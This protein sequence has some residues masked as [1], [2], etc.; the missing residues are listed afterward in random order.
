MNEVDTKTGKINGNGSRELRE[1]S[2][3]GWDNGQES[4]RGTV[5]VSSVGESSLRS[6]RD[7]AEIHAI[8]NALKQTGWNRKRAAQ[9]L[10]ISYRGL[11]YKIRRHNITPNGNGGLKSVT[12]SGEVQS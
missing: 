4:R 2:A 10:S 3:Q 6:F 1:D 8:S 9:L 11:L 7:E 12:E 5:Y